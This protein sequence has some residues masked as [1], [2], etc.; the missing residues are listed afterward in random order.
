MELR[1]VEAFIA[2][3]EELH[4]GRAA[5]RLRMAQSP[6]SQ[7]IKK[8]ER[9]LGVQLFERDTRRVSLTP[10]GHAF[11]P[12]ARRTLEEMDLARRAARATGRRIYGSVSIGFSG[13]LNHKT[14]PPLTRA[15]RQT[16]PDIDITLHGGQLSSDSL[17]Q[18][19][20]GIYDLAFV[21]LPARRHGVALRRIS[22]EPLGAVL[23]IDHPLAGEAVL[24]LAALADDPFVTMPGGSGS[25]VR[26]AMV[27]ACSLAGFRPRIEQTVNDPYTVL[28]MVAGGVGVSLMPTCMADILPA[29]TRFV[30]LDGEPALIIAGLAWSEKEPSTALRAVLEVAER[31]L[32]DNGAAE[33]T[34]A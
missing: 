23:P 27:T 25:S 15:V 11:L 22:S 6:L 14:L 26:E 20:R 17:D 30:P 8:L 16:Y 2:V 32:P 4:F 29:D 31:V 21:G 24:N 13:A 28:S 7:T 10:A 18:V 3:A 1:W 12:H 19:E 34:G 33:L 9:Q 5:E